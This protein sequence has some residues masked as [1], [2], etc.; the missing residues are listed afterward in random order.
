[1]VI[2]NLLSQGALG[3]STGTWRAVASENDTMPDMGDD[4]GDPIN[5]EFSPLIGSLVDVTYDFNPTVKPSGGYQTIG[6]LMIEGTVVSDG[7]KTLRKIGIIDNVAVPN[8][9]IIFEDA[10]IP[11]DVVLND[12]ILVRY[13]MPIG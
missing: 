1:M 5:N 12:E 6:D 9:N 13:T 4:S 7:S 10:V 2:A 11:K 8:Q 3:T